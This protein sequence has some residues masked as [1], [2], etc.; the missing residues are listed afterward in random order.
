MREWIVLSIIFLLVVIVYFI[1][2]IDRKNHP[3]KD[4]DEPE[5]WT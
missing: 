1:G 4:D 2:R 5:F 3:T